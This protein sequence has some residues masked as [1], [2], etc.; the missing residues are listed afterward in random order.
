MKRPRFNPL[1]DP[2]QTKVI[3]PS[4]NTT[5]EPDSDYEDV[6]SSEDISL[7]DMSLVSSSE[8]QGLEDDLREFEDDGYNTETTDNTSP[9]KTHKTKKRKSSAQARTR[10]SALYSPNAF[11]PVN[12]W[13]GAEPDTSLPG[14]LQGS[15]NIHL[16]ASPLASD[17]NHSS[18][19]HPPL[20]TNSQSGDPGA[21]TT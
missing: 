14:T 3:S 10:I 6:S 1:P 16:S 13:T 15:K 20:N 2:G 9:S 4:N 5:P 19:P 8:M 11:P 18:I 12:L 21:E 17:H 7:E